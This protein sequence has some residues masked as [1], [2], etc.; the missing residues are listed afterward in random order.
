MPFIYLFI[1]LLC[2]LGTIINPHHNANCW[3]SKRKYNIVYAFI[4]EA[5]LLRVLII[6][7][8]NRYI[9]IFSITNLKIGSITVEAYLKFLA[10]EL[11]Y[12]AIFGYAR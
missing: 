7:V 8:L 5:K 6:M 12:T 4:C 2:L 10:F 3:I 1:Y 11:Q 9:S